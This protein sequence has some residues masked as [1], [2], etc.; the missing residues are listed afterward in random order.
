MHVSTTEHRPT[1]HYLDRSATR[2]L[3]PSV[4]D[5]VMT[6]GTQLHAAGAN[7]LTVVRRDLPPDLRDSEE[8][9]QAEDWI[10]VTAD[11]G[12]LIT[13]YRREG[14]LRFVRRKCDISPRRRWPRRSRRR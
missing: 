8:A 7:H 6:W 4:E 14:A 3:R 2:H 10:I 13:C 11:D 9:A 5:F 12:S 1:H